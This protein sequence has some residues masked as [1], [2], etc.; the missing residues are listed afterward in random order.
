MVEIILFFSFAFII[1]VFKIRL[2]EIKNLN[3]GVQYHYGLCLMNLLGNVFMLYYL[4]M[5]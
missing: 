3:R 1:L 2:T 4:K 5:V